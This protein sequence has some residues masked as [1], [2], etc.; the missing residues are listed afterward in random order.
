[1]ETI[2]APFYHCRLVNVSSHIICAAPFSLTP[3]SSFP[4]RCLPDGDHEATGEPMRSGRRHKAA[5]WIGTFEMTAQGGAAD[6]S[7]RDNDRRT[8]TPTERLDSFIERPRVAPRAIDALEQLI[9]VRQRGWT[10]RR[11][12]EHGMPNRTIGPLEIWPP[13]SDDTQ[14]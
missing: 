1:V 5:R 6:Q 3:L 4:N 7:G 13:I 9:V 11:R 14:R 8:T 2:V 10:P 12:S